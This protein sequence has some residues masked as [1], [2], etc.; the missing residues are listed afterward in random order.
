MLSETP[1]PLPIISSVSIFVYSLFQ[2]MPKYH[3]SSKT[4]YS[5][6]IS[7]INRLTPLIFFGGGFEIFVFSLF[8][9]MPKYHESSK[10]EYSDSTSFINRLTPL[11]FFFRV[12]T[13]FQGAK[14]GVPP[15]KCNFF[16]LQSYFNILD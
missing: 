16:W 3:E 6:S 1:T 10:M 8:Q 11:I 7:F 14:R 13:F 2:T 5:D 15:K 4:E 9:T 12:L